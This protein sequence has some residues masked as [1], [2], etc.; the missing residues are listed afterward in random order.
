LDLAVAGGV[1]IALLAVLWMMHG[2]KRPDPKWTM[3]ES[4]IQIAEP[5][6][7]VKD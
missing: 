5:D 1:L 2:S 7:E 3:L 4:L 6:P